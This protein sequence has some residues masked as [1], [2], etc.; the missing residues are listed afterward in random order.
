MRRDSAREK[1]GAVVEGLGERGRVGG[2]WRVAMRIVD[3]EGE[4]VW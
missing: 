1:L 2:N 3:V 4:V